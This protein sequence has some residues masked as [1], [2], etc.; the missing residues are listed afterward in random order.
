MSSFDLFVGPSTWVGN[1]AVNPGVWSLVGTTTPVS[2]PSAVI[3]PVNGV[4]NPAGANPGPITFGPG[5]YGIALR[6]IGHA[7]RYTNGAFTF[8]DANMTV[9]TGGASNAFLTLPTFSPR[10]I[11]GAINYTL[12][13]TAMPFAQRQPYGPGCY[14]SYQSF[15]E[16]FPSSVF[17]D[18]NNT[19][20]Y[21]TFDPSSNRYSSIVAGTTPL[22]T[23]LSP[24]LGH[25]ANNNIV[26][27]LLPAASPQPIL[28]PN[29]GGVGLA[30]TTVEMCSN[31]YVNLL[32]TTAATAT[33]GVVLWLTSTAVRIGNWHNVDPSLGGMTHYDYN[34]AS[35]SH[36]F[37]WLAVPDEPA[38]GGVNTFQLAFFANGDVEM[39]WGLRSMLGGGGWPT[40][41]G[42]SPGAT[43][44]DPGNMDLS[45]RLTQLPVFS[46]GGFDRDPLTLT[47]NVNPTLGSTVNLT[48]SNGTG[49]SIGIMFIGVADLG[50]LSPAG[51]DLGFLGAPGCVANVN[52]TPSASPLISN[53]GPPGMTV[54]FAIPAGPVSLVGQS[55]YAQSIWVDP[56]GQ[57]SFFSPGVGMLT[58]NAVRLKI[59]A[60]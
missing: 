7:W 15:Y 39:R 38:T 31:M 56:L 8:A 49:A 6:A 5:T 60:F 47:A 9:V 11:N 4:L 29:I 46:T 33:P 37:T 41:I 2:I 21:M 34:V 30:T 36:I 59:G 3:T 58:S 12:G 40:L 28:F 10:S 54:P 53:L 55:F 50:A 43:S 22:V 45:F 52:I 26:I 23:P 25:L 13:G 19:S 20:M 44:L 57:N 24:S 48:T 18:M 51:L 35:A 32:G 1:V 42:F 16:L 14:A 27:S 17:V